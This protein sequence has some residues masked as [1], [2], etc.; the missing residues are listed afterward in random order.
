MVESPCENIC[1]LDYNDVCM[2][3]KRTRDEIKRWLR[4]SDEEK[5]QVIEL[6]KKRKTETNYDHYA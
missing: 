1:M 2:G 3:C 6:C 5:L 4:Y